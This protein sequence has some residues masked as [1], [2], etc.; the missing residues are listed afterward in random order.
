MSTQIDDKK[1]L[2]VAVE[3][4]LAAGKYLKNAVGKGMDVEYKGD[5]DL[6]THHDKESQRIIHDI[7]NQQFPHHSLLG[8][9][10]LDETRDSHSLWLIDPIDGTTNFSRSIPA[11]AVSIGFAEA[12]EA[13]VGVVYIPL[14]DE[15]F[16]AVKGEGAFLN[17][18]PIRVTREPELGKS[19]LATGFPYDRWTSDVNNVGH[20]NKFIL[21]ALGIRRM[22]A[23]AVDLCY[24]AA[25]RFDGFWELKLK[26]WDT[27]AAFLIVREAGGKVTDFSGN[28]FNPYMKECLASNGLIHDDMLNILKS[29]NSKDGREK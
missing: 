13:R 10:D 15:L 19:L 14:L 7:L 25:G 22:G 26:P 1:I 23:A 29:D 20:F 4:A 8:E 3:A 17:G 18:T 6:V 5:I 11:F 28:P 16:T 9:E 27:A 21:Q 2:D 24:T 12:G